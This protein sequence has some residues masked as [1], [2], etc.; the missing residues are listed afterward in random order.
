[1]RSCHHEGEK[2]ESGRT[3]SGKAGRERKGKGSGR[4]CS[5][6]ILNLPNSA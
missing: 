6:N 2:G 3:K 5:M 1:M 4:E